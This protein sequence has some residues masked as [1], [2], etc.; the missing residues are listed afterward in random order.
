MPRSA[1]DSRARNETARV[2]YNWRDK[3]LSGQANIANVGRIPFYTRDYGWLDASISYHF[4]DHLTVGMEGTNLLQTERVSYYG[5]ET[6]PQ[7]VYINDLQITV[8][9]TYRF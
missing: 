7:N 4:N 5:V 6:R 2:A 1:R 3:F 9:V 8:I